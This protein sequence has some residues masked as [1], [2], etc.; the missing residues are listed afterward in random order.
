MAV[1]VACAPV[2]LLL[3]ELNREPEDLWS[4]ECRWCANPLDRRFFLDEG[5]EAPYDAVVQYSKVEEPDPQSGRYLGHTRLI[6]ADGW[7]RGLRWAGGLDGSGDRL[8][9]PILKHLSALLQRL[10]PSDRAADPKDRV[11]I[12]FPVHRRW[13]IRT[14][15]R[16]AL[17]R[18][19]EDLARLIKMPD[20]S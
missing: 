20:G 16:G 6:T 4:R 8:S 9:E 10:P 7:V 13:V 1:P 3:A 12:A 2:C 18:Q 15:R 14:Y 5:E 19:V 17:P 11:L